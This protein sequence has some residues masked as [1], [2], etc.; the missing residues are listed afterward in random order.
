MV[1]AKEPKVL[2]YKHASSTSSIAQSADIGRQ[3]AN[4]KEMIKTTTAVNLPH[5]YGL[6]GHLQNLF[7]E[8]EVSGE[9]DLNLPVRKAIIDHVVF[10]PEIFS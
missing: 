9:L 7:D 8:K 4:I 1:I 5:G 2:S 3:F 10:Y 6:K